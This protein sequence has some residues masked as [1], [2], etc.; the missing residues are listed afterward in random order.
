MKIKKGFELIKRDGQNIV[1]A[2][3]GSGVTADN[4]IVLSETASFLWNLL[5]ENDVT[6]AE[7]LEG[8]LNNFNISNVLAL[9]DIYIFIRTMKEN[10]II[11]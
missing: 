3:K 9:G 4:H 2:K 10:G 11:E 1:A 5:S 7:M 6:K 8:L